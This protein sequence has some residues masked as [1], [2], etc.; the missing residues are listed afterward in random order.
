MSRQNDEIIAALGLVASATCGWTAASFRSAETVPA[1]GLPARFDGPRPLG[2][3]LLFLV[4]PELPTRLHR[5][6][7]DQMYHHYRGDDLEVLLLHPDG[8]GEVVVLGGDPA[9]GGLMQLLIPGGTYHMSR[10]RG[11]H[12]YALLATTAWPAPVDGDADFGDPAALAEAYPAMR[13]AIADFCG[14]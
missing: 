14:T 1:D 12:G 9:A 8:R 7:S 4:A 10:S 2:S 5:L 3:A 11:P 6:R 13:A